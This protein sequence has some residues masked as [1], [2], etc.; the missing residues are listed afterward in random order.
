MLLCAPGDNLHPPRAMACRF[1]CR[2]VCVLISAQCPAPSSRGCTYAALGGKRVGVAEVAADHV[3]VQ[4]LRGVSG[5]SSSEQ[6]VEGLCVL[7]AAGP[8][9]T[10]HLFAITEDGAMSCWV[11]LNSGVES[12][13]RKE[14]LCAIIT[15][16]CLFGHGVSMAWLSTDTDGSSV[17]NRVERRPRSGHP[18]RECPRYVHAHARH[19]HCSSPFLLA[20]SYNSGHM[21]TG[22]RGHTEIENCATET[23]RIGTEVR[24]SVLSLRFG[25]GFRRARAT[26]VVPVEVREREK[27]K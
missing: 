16:R 5:S 18:A 22:R 7:P 4:A 11:G 10:A 8:T 21:E 15:K 3:R 13:Q 14:I 25:H 27:L 9:P 12:G 20:Q 26:G 19:S 24:E 1:L 6:R 23:E 2:L 17:A